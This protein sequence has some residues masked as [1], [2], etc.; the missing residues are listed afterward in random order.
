MYFLCP[1]FGLFWDDKLCARRAML[2][3]ACIGQGRFRHLLLPRLDGPKYLGSDR[4]LEDGVPY[5]FVITWMVTGTE[6]RA[7]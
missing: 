2:C 4:C 5:W 3:R 1:V 7:H 6:E